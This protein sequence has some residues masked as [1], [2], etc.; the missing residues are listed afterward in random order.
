MIAPAGVPNDTVETG[1]PRLAASLAA[2]ISERP[3]VV[4]PSESSL[5][6]TT[7]GLFLVLHTIVSNLFGAIALAFFVSHIFR[8]GLS[9]TQKGYVGLMVIGMLT[10]WLPY[11]VASTAGV[12]TDPWNLTQVALPTSFAIA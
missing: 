7:Q 1:S 9:G 5:Q 2:S 4:S 12:D 8:A 11:L 6:A 10:A 3:V